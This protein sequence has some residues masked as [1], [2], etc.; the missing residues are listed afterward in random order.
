MAST[1]DEVGRIPPNLTRATIDHM[2]NTIFT[3]KSNINIPTV[4]PKIVADSS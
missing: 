2:Y 4:S 1:I 3:I